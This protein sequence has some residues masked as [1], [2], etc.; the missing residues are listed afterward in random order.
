MD[1]S[2]PIMLECTEFSKRERV[3]I[4]YLQKCLGKDPCHLFVNTA[5]TELNNGYFSLAHS[6]EGRDV[7]VYDF[8]HT[9]AANKATEDSLELQGVEFQ[10][11]TEEDILPKLPSGTSYPKFTIGRK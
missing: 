9:T 10:S 4:E 3:Q 11:V 5:N 1:I 6:S 8:I 2:K 7:Y